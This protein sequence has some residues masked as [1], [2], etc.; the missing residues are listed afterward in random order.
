M[1]NKPVLQI[2]AGM[3][4]KNSETT[5]KFYKWLEDRHVPE[6]FE[7]KGFKRIM[8]CRR[9]IGAEP[10]KPLVT[11]YPEYIS[12]T[13]F[14]S[15]K[16]MED[17]PKSTGI[18]HLDKDGL[19]SWGTEIGRKKIWLV[20][21]EETKTYERKLEKKDNR[22]IQIVSGASPSDPKTAERFYK[23]LDNEH[24]PH[25]FE[26]KGMVKATN[27]RRIEAELPFEPSVKDYPYYIT[28]FEFNSRKDLEGLMASIKGNPPASEEWGTE[29]GYKKIWLVTYEVVKCWER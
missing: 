8:N 16:D 26:F 23:W 15:K 29:V 1:A 11:D 5:E 12:I 25:Q 10:F 20:T 13:E 3:P 14:Y 24:V 2:V 19:E 17:F 4:A 27:Y 18:P 21:Y 7:Y 22:V 6:M 9:I 28:I